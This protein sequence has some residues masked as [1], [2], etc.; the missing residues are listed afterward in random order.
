MFVALDKLNRTG[1]LQA[2]MTLALPTFG[3]GM[4]WGTAV[5][6]WHKPAPERRNWAVFE[7]GQRAAD[8]PLIEKLHTRYVGMVE[9]MRTTLTMR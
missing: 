7:S 9:K 2:G 1:R 4:A 5:T 6:R 8:S 3:A